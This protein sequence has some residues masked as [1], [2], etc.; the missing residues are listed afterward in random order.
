LKTILYL[1][2]V[3]CVVTACKKKTTDISTT[4][5]LTF[6]SFTQGKDSA[7]VKFNFTDGDGDI[8]FDAKDTTSPYTKKEGHFYNFFVTYYE[9]HNGV[10][11]AIP[12][13]PPL[14]VRLPRIVVESKDK[15]IQGDLY[16][17]L[18]S[19]YY[20]P[21]LNIGDTIK[22]D[23]YLEDRALKKSAVVS[24]GNIITKY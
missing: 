7:I 14:N 6:V 5:T 22:F 2:V 15:T 18:P 13:N 11:K 24:S 3:L 17:A 1:L 12:L 10:F 9:K 4:P 23:Y 20:S 21:L 16:V 19:P 8:G